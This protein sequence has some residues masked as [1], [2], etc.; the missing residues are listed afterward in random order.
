MTSKFSEVSLHVKARI[1]GLLY[2][3][4]FVGGLFA[5]GY[6]SA[7]II[8]Y[9]D[10]VATMQNIIEKESLYRWGLGIHVVIALCNIPLAAMFYDIFKIANKSLARIIVLFIIVAVAIESVNLL[11]QFAP[12]ILLH[13]SAFTS[14]ESAGVLQTL[15]YIPLELQDVGFSLSLTFVGFYCMLAGY[16]IFRLG[17]LPRFVGVLLAIGGFC[18][19]GHSFASFLAPEFANSLFPYILMPSALGEASLTLAL[20]FNG[21]TVEQEKNLTA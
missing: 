2:L 5:V 20:L 4:I 1:A 12:L 18:Y 6:V 14:L 11:N 13:G 8:V 15:A 17:F 16:L 10:P 3:I 21:M 19:A 7:N 9:G